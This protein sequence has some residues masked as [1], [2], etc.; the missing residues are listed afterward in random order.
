MDVTRA[1][2][3]AVKGWPPGTAAL[4]ASMGISSTSLY[5]KVSPTHPGAHASPEEMLE[6]M[7]TTGDHGA[8]FLLAERLHYIVLPEPRAEDGMRGTRALAL[9]VREFGE[10]AART[11]DSLDDGRITGNELA[12]IRAEALEAIAA[13]HALIRVAE[14]MYAAGAPQ[15]D[16]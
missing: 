13:I 4:A 14:A 10:L 15:R 2:Q 3:R 12:R 16:E 8:L 7:E 11:A 1:L 6:I 9:A 5:H